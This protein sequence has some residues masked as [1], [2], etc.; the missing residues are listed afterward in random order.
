[1]EKN[2]FEKKSV[3]AVFGIIAL[4]GGFIFLNFG[5]FSFGPTG[6]VISTGIY[7]LNLISVIGLVL[8]VCSAILIVYAIVKR[9]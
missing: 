3:V 5:Y 7:S 9:Q 2:F 1:M 8:I 4:I 6:N